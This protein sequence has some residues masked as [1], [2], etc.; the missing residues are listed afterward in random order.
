MK[1]QFL[2]SLFLLDCFH[3]AK[4]TKSSSLGAYDN[5]QA[6]QQPET[7]IAKH[8]FVILKNYVLS[9]FLIHPAKRRV[10]LATS[11]SFINKKRY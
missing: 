7:R 5:D 4:Q 8:L 9:F 3:I 11:V 10:V 6:Y 2:L 1:F